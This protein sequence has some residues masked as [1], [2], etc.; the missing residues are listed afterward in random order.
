MGSPV[1]V[2]NS[3]GSECDDLDPGENLLMIDV[4]ERNNRESPTETDASNNESIQLGLN[5]DF[6]EVSE[7]ILLY[8]LPHVIVGFLDFAV[9]ASVLILDLEGI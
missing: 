9:R 2:T 1:L 5:S 3:R 7:H 4:D 8:F 6:S